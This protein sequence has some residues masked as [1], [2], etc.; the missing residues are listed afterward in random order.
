[1]KALP[2]RVRL[3]AWYFA[4]L[5]LSLSLISVV[6]LFAMYRSIHGAVD[7]ELGDRVMVIRRLMERKLKTS[8]LEDLQH[9]LREHTGLRPGGDLTQIADTHGSW[10][11]RS[12]SM[13]HFGVPLPGDTNNAPR[14]RTEYFNG[15]PL[16]LH[17]ES[18][19]VNG[20][21]YWIEVAAPMDD[22]HEAIIHFRHFLLLAV[23]FLLLI[24]TAGGYFMGRRALAPVD[25]IMDATQRIGAQNLS[26]RLSVPQTGD[27][28]QRLSE[29]L[30]GMLERIEVAFKKI[31]QFTADASHELRTPLAIMRTRAELALRKPRP[32]AEY[33][34]ELQQLLGDLEGTSELVERLM[35]LARADSGASVL[36][37]ANVELAD[38]LGQAAAQGAVLAAAKQITFSTQSLPEA[39]SVHGDP[40]ALQRL[41]LILI[42]NAIKYTPSGGE[43][44][45]CSSVEGEF[46]SVSIRD[47]GVGIPES[48]LPSIFER[49]YRADK[50]RSRESG[51][52]GLGL[53]IAHWTV[54]TH[55]GAIEVE[56]ELGIGSTFRVRLPLIST[57]PA[58]GQPVTTQA[59]A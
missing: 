20:Q 13:T 57:T 48:D 32:V 5:A 54:E 26:N 17:T 56:S 14:N 50:A 24:A 23:P 15:I 43:V 18:A 46:V 25:A 55:R 49:F 45:V 40:Q 22:F 38:V 7:E 30:N 19:S 10:I 3:T 33:R 42:D 41:F 9:E 27:E 29:T 11:F 31:T 4:V 6:A 34:D 12:R 44:S 36:R 39:C 16:R 53:A 52:A 35:L 21:S 58:H 51:G 47:N 2:L 1:M 28:L 37:F 8:T 59:P